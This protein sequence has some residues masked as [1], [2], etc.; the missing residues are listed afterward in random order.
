MVICE[1]RDD[2][3]IEIETEQLKKDEQFRYLGSLTSENGKSD[4][5]LNDRPK[6]AARLYLGLN[7]NFLN[8]RE[9][10]TKRKLAAYNSSY[11]HSLTSGCESLTL[12]TK[13]QSQIQAVEMKYLRKA[14][15]K[16]RR[17]KIRNGTIRGHFSTELLQIRINCSKMRCYGHVVRISDA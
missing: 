6:A 14:A 11:A 13:T 3:C 15:E 2:H 16:S 8:K 4:K 10:S 12:T 9:L 17:E 1:E 7:Q 5:D